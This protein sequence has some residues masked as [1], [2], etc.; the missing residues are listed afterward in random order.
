MVSFPLLY[1][2]VCPKRGTLA[3]WRHGARPGVCFGGC[4]ECRAVMAGSPKGAGLHPCCG[5]CANPVIAVQP[6]THPHCVVLVG[7]MGGYRVPCDGGFLLRRSH[8][9]RQGRMV[10]SMVSSFPFCSPDAIRG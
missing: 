2:G 4:L 1:C 3:A 9:F 5:H 6:P 8:G 10:S 7:A